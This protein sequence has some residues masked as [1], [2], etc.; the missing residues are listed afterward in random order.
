MIRE[1][2]SPEALA[3]VTTVASLA[4]AHTA[5]TR[6]IGTKGAVRFQ[7]EV[8]AVLAGVL[9]PYL[10]HARPVSAQ[11]GKDGGVWAHSP[12]VGHGAFWG[13]ALAMQAAGLLHMRLGIKTGEG[14][15]YGSDFGGIPTKLWPTERLLEM[16]DAVGVTGTTSWDITREAEQRRIEVPFTSLVLVRRMDSNETIPDRDLPQEELE[17]MRS[18]LRSLNAAAQAFDICGCLRPA[19][20]R[21]FRGGL[22]LGG[23]CYAVG[24]GNYQSMDGADRAKITINGQGT[25][26]L[27]IRS[28]FLTILLGLAGARELPRQNDLYALP[29]LPRDACKAWFT[30]SFAQGKPANRWSKEASKETG[31]P[32]PTTIR[33]A[34]LEAYP[35]AFG[36]PLQDI[37]LS[38]D[39]RA[40]LPPDK[41]QKAAGQRLPNI[42]ADVI[43]TVVDHFVQTGRIALPVHDSVIVARQDA[44]EARQVLSEAFRMRVGLT[45]RIRG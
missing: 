14:D 9:R 27:D 30:Q 13:Q 7:R 2:S 26:E 3:L 37:V 12:M 22:A 5:R 23:R 43:C 44:D 21:V 25:V 39:L 35:E 41:H 1:L 29:G 20:R 24:A 17:E 45:P 31:W 19:F 32:L 18:S 16:C 6:P 11:K 36:R 10:A 15:G 33:R 40:S 38:S 8:G 34:A 4:M 42:E 28:S